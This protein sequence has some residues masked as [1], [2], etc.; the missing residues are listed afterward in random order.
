MK[1]YLLS[2]FCAGI[3][4]VAL[5]SEPAT[6]QRFLKERQL[7]LND[8]QLN[9]KTSLR[10]TLS[11]SDDVRICSF[12]AYDC[13]WDDESGTAVVNENSGVNSGKKV[14]L[15]Y[16][17]D[18]QLCLTGF[19]GSF[20]IPV[21]F[22]DTSDRL[23]I[24]SGV[25]LTT[26]VNE[27]GSD[28]DQSASMRGSDENSL[29]D[30]AWSIYA[31][32][33]SWLE[34][35]DNYDDIHGYYSVDGSIV[36]DD[37]F[38]FLVEEIYYEDDS[39][40][41]SSWTMS[42]IYCDLM[43]LV[44]NGTHEFSA[45]GSS[46][47]SEANYL[48]YL[49]WIGELGHGGLS[50]RPIDPRPLKPKPIRPR[51]IRPKTVVADESED[52][53]FSGSDEVTLLGATKTRAKD[54]RGHGG[55]SPRPIDPRPPKPVPTPTP[56]NIVLPKDMKTALSLSV[57]DMPL[58]STQSDTD[59][60]LGYGNL[61]SRPID[62]RPTP[63]STPVFMGVLDPTGLNAAVPER[64][65]GVR[66]GVETPH[67]SLTTVPVYMYF[68]GDV[69]YVYNLYGNDY[70][71]NTMNLDD[72]I[73]S[74]SSQLLKVISGSVSDRSIYNSSSNND[75]KSNTGTWIG[76]SIMWNTTY[77]CDS[78][79]NFKSYFF[80][81]NKLKIGFENGAVNSYAPEFAQPV[82]TD[83]QVQFRAVSTTPNAVVHVWSYDA[84]SG[85]FDEVGN[86]CSVPRLDEPY[87]VCFVAMNEVDDY[88]SDGVWLEYEV[89]ALAY[90]L[91]DVNHDRAV[92][93]TDVTTLIAHVL[94]S[95]GG[96]FYSAQANV[97]G[98]GDG[99]IDVSDV[100]AL[101]NLILHQQ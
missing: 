58:D 4:L 26:F 1:K 12:Y 96:E 94:G 54:F 68:Y 66:L 61:A 76:D 8:N 70:C 65:E 92:D 62:T 64:V 5:A 28:W 69:L 21:C 81:N 14:S 82:V 32:P 86:P 38:A 9:R 67:T 22:D 59:E 44:P 17:S 48:N 40:I 10:S 6:L 98:D 23:F 88:W 39:T 29:E 7:T 3:A 41:V 97:D 24:E 19:Y 16:N 74:F 2:V 80:M 30:K 71:W 53:A 43:V 99:A 90:D 50:P 13:D 87:W 25:V 34:G 57:V 79:G 73:V 35:N 51:P 63:E 36:F 91:G 11:G 55:L 52:N 101:I 33:L 15:E 60:S 72:S 56:K 85:S 75:R 31:M 47:N 46:G 95:A 100:T 42:P 84:E 49:T 77:I 78:A 45:R 93:V 37:D 18:G 89:P 83:N 27:F 20:N